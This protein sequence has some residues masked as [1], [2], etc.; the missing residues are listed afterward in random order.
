M[1]K[2]RFGFLI[3][4]I[5]VFAMCLGLA[6]KAASTDTDDKNVVFLKDTYIKYMIINEKSITVK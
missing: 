5:Y 6:T 1:Q 3:I 4:L 2:T